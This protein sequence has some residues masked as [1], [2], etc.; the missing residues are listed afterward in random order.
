MTP[1][2]GVNPSIRAL[3]SMDEVP[4][5]EKNL[6][7]VVEVPKKGYE[8]E[9]SHSAKPEL[10]LNTA[11]WK[12]VSDIHIVMPTIRQLYLFRS[13]E[14][15]HYH[16]DKDLLEKAVLDSGLDIALHIHKP[17]ENVLD[18]PFVK[19]INVGF[20][21]ASKTI[22]STITWKSIATTL[23]NETIRPA[24]I[25]STEISSE[26]ANRKSKPTLKRQQ[27]HK[28]VGYTSGQCLIGRDELGIS[29]PAVKPT[30]SDHTKAMVALTAL[31]RSHVF[32]DLKDTVY[33][34][35]VNLERASS[36]AE[37]LAPNN[38][39]EAMRS[40]LSNAQHPCGCH[41]D[42][43]NDPH[44]HFST[45]ITFSILVSINGVV[46]HL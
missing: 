7:L 34:D 21:R 19:V 12:Y 29:F 14:R 23:F 30:D 46:Y 27:Y 13:L 22:I 9:Y 17:T 35:A 18:N 16:S 5:D 31:L 15:K 1:P 8:S 20:D 42:A 24:E 40:A 10:A 26:L 45:V 39:L 25:A 28:D 11:R 32:N 33:F 41:E 44:P 4:N 3:S 37:N 36:F 2:I 6:G 38:L 43:H